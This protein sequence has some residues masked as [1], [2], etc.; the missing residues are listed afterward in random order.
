LQV[1]LIDK[2]DKFVFKPLLYEV[3]N[4]TAS[5]EDVAPTFVNLLS[6]YTVNF[7]KVTP[8]FCP[9]QCMA[10][11]A[12]QHTCQ[13]SVSL[14]LGAV[15]LSPFISSAPEIVAACQKTAFGAGQGAIH[16]AIPVRP[17]QK[18]LR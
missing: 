12:R 4:G 16:S 17:R 3:V 11:K 6:P 2:A 13:W 1:T 15:Q 14:A 8:A 18:L 7:I 5:A 9:T 10:A